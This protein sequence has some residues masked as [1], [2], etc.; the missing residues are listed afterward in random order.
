MTDILSAQGSFYSPTNRQ[1]KVDK[2]A[3]GVETETR[4]T[5]Y[6]YVFS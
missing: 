2:E 5:V 3:Y 6:I 1:L 4:I